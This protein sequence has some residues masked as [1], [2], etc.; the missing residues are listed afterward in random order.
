MGTRGSLESPRLNQSSDCISAN[1][2]CTGLA[3]GVQHLCMFTRA[4][5]GATYQGKTSDRVKQ[6]VLNLHVPSHEFI[7]TEPSALMRFHG[8]RFERPAR[9]VADRRNF[10]R[11][12]HIRPRIDAATRGKCANV[13]VESQ[14]VL[15][16]LWE[17][18]AR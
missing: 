9:T 16:T 11:N 8:V 15:H 13:T 10:L 1:V 6:L 4:T 5:R 3:G 12:V 18:L 14:K 17:S 7:V 2:T